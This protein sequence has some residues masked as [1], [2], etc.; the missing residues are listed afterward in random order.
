MTTMINDRKYIEQL[1]D[2]ELDRLHAD[3]EFNSRG[4]IMPLDIVNLVNSIRDKGLLQPISV[5]PYNNNERE[6]Y[7][8]EFKIIL[9]YCRYAAFKILNHPTIPCV[10]RP[11]MPEDEAR[12]LNIQ[13]N[14]KRKDLNILQE[15]KSIEKFK[16]AGWTQQMVC[17]AL[18]VSMEW[19]RNRFVV[20]SFPE[21]IQKE[22]A[23]GT[24]NQ[25]QIKDLYSLP[26]EEQY[27]AVRAIKD[28]R[29]KGEKNIKVKK[30]L[31]ANSK[32]GRNPASMNKMLDFLMDTVGPSF[33]TRVLAWS[34]GNISTLDLMT[35][36]KSQM[37]IKGKHFTIPQDDF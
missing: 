22:C 14:I 12:V 1:Q 37:V 31:A 20:L 17:D 29:I 9:G 13:E 32:K 3:E 6:K 36:V 23:N 34:T 25:I 2:I 28:Q 4:H 10:V 18:G 24:L 11:W 26:L 21:D 35:D 27:K 15:A 8:K 7:G 19:V 5:Y 16:I 30:P 33:A